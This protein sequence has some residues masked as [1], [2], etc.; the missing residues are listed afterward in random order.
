MTHP[1]SQKEEFKDR[2]YFIIIIFIQF[3]D[4]GRNLNMTSEL[5]AKVICAGKHNF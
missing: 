4:P 1:N 3:P 5:G 2:V